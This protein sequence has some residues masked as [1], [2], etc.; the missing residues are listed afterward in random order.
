MVRNKLS[1]INGIL[2]RL[3]YYFPQKIL[4]TLYKSLFT[5]HVN[6]GSLLWGEAGEKLDKIQKK[7]I[8][9]IT[10]NNYTAHTEPLIKELNLLKVKDMFDLKILRFLFKLYHHELLPYFNIYLLNPSFKKIWFLILC[11]HMLYQ[12]RLWHMYMQNLASYINWFVIKTII[13]ISEDLILRRIDDQSFSLIGF[14]QLV[15]NRILRNFSYTYSL[16]ICYTCGRI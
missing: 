9:T 13:A 6:Y 1:R 8:R 11:V 10:Y 12:F 14:N 3:K 16:Q 4:I 7:T 2:H 15:I 5:P